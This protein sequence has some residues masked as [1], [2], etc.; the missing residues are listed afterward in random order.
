MSDQWS[1]YAYPEGTRKV[2]IGFG[3]RNEG[4]AIYISEGGPI[5]TTGKG[6][7]DIKVYSVVVGKWADQEEATRAA[8]ELADQVILKHKL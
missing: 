4:T 1:G 7:V 2:W 5:D 6:A 8:N 3:S